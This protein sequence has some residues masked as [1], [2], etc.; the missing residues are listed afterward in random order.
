MH[1]TA[2]VNVK[3]LR[4]AARCSRNNT[5]QRAQLLGMGQT[6]GKPQERSYQIPTVRGPPRVRDSDPVAAVRLAVFLE[7]LKRVVVGP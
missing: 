7:K 4:T 3:C 6:M 2:R 5:T 1:P